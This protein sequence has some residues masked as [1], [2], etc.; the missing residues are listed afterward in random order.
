M[1]RTI[2]VECLCWAVA[3]QNTRAPGRKLLVKSIL[4]YTAGLVKNL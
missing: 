3:V 4:V 1:A 2:A